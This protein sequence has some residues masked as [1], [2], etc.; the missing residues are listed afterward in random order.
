MIKAILRMG[1]NVTSINCNVAKRDQRRRVNVDLSESFMVT[2]VPRAL[3][4]N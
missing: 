3:L 2:I 4:L 1:S